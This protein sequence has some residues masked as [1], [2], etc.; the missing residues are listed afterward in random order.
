MTTTNTAPVT[1]PNAA[2]QLLCAAGQLLE[3]LDTTDD[4]D[5]TPL[6]KRHDLTPAVVARAASGAKTYSAEETALLLKGI[7]AALQDLAAEGAGADCTALF[8]DLSTTLAVRKETGRLLQ[9]RTLARLLIIRGDTGS[10]KTSALNVIMETYNRMHPQPVVFRLEATAAWGGTAAGLLSSMMQALGLQNTQQQSHAA[11]IDR[12]VG[13]I[14]ERGSGLIVQIDEVHDLGVAALRTLKTLL[15]RCLLL[16]FQVACHRRLFRTLETE[17]ADDL[18][19]L[20][21]NRLLAIV[22]LP[23]P[24]V[25][26]AQKLLERMLPQLKGPKG[27]IE[28]AAA[29]LAKHSRQNGN[30]AFVRQVIDRCQIHARQNGG[31]LSLTDVETCIRAECRVRN[32]A[33]ASL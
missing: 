33:G 24:Q 2:A 27:T 21:G 3:T 17:H 18:S 25:E 31:A 14:N 10:G 19:Q 26:D 32:R 20:T 5:L 11:R 9:S 28:T 6:L 30:L 15:N 16:K 13:H 8:G 12:L 23:S 4:R 1:A 22:D 29:A 7:A